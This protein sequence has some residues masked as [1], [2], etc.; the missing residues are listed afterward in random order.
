MPTVIKGGDLKP[1]NTNM[2]REVGAWNIVPRM[3][4]GGLLGP[5]RYIDIDDKKLHKFPAIKTDPTWIYVNPNPK[6]YCME[7]QAIVKG[8]GFIPSRCLE[9]YKVVVMPRSFHELMQ[10]Y[11]L[12]QVLVKENPKCWCKCG[13]EAR[14]FVPRHYGGYFYNKGIEVGKSRYK[15]VRDAVSSAI[16]PDVN[17]ILKR[18]CTEFELS[19]GPSD[20]YVQPEGAQDIE[21]YFWENVEISTSSHTQPEFVRQNTIRRWMDFAWGRGDMTVKLYNNGEPLVRPSVTYHEGEK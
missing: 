17:V 16:S 18:Y 9:C 19:F 21:K 14:E 20:Q 11:E 7:Y 12:E 8:F 2:Y 15:T 1:F 10:L 4:A 5:G 13:I 6:L 3:E